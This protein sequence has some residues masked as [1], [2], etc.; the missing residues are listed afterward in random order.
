MTVTWNPQVKMSPII[1]GR[2]A[3]MMVMS[4]AVSKIIPM[5]AAVMTETEIMP[6]SHRKPRN[7]KGKMAKVSAK[8]S[9][10]VSAKTSNKASSNHKAIL[11]WIS[12]I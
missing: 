11:T 3:L 5:M 9:A 7:R 6:T 8:A 10:K 4:R 1:L 12:L 2:R